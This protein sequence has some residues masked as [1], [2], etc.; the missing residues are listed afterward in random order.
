M[1]SPLYRLYWMCGVL[2]GVFMMA[3]LGFVLWGVIMRFFPALYLRG[4]D[5][6]A[7]YCM[8]A[9]AFLA[10]AYTFAHGDHIRVTLLIQRFRGG[11]RRALE[12][13]CLLLAALLSGFFAFYGCRMVWWSWKFHD[14]SQAHDATPLWIPQLGMGIG[15]AILFIAVV[16][17]L[18]LVLLGRAPS[19]SGSAATE[20]HVE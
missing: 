19:G 2:A 15:A 5:S 17:E 13:W 7:G 11:T 12:L 18:V 3:L 9:S 14:I 20:Q 4:T 8:A 16:E 1:K 6:Y 10:L